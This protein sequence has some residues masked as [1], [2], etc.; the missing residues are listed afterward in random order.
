MV[1]L[2]I[3]D[4]TRELPVEPVSGRPILYKEN[5]IFKE[6]LA[7]PAGYACSGYEL[8]EV[9]PSPFR[10]MLR[11]SFNVPMI[12]G[13]A[14]SN[15]EINLYDMNGALIHHFAEGRFQ[16]GHYSVFWNGSLAANTALG[17]GFY[18]LRMKAPN[19]EKR[20]KIVKVG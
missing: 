7:V 5:G 19:F 4:G 3:W 12:Q 20:V 16:P 14:S 6:S 10:D 15:V 2:R 18:L 1:Q 13:T 8:S 9:Y 17:P 11:I